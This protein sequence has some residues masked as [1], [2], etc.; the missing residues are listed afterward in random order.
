MSFSVT[1]CSRSATSLLSWNR[2]Y[3]FSSF[4]LRS[5]AMSFSPAYCLSTCP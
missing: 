1:H 5:S 2:W 4:R 3:M